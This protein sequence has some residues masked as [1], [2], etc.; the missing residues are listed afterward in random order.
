LGKDNTGRAIKR[1]FRP[2]FFQK[3]SRTSVVEHYGIRTLLNGT[4]LPGPDIGRR[5]A[6]ILRA[7]ADAGFEVGIHCWDHVRWQDHVVDADERWTLHEL[8]QAVQ[9]FEEIF[10]HAVK[11][12]GAAGWQMNA[13]AYSWQARMGLQYASDTRGQYPF[14]PVVNDTVLSCI[15]MPTTLPTLDELLGLN[16]TTPENVHERLLQ[17]TQDE[18]EYGHVFTLHAELEG[19]KLLPA[20]ERMLQGWIRQGYDL[21]SMQEL[22]QRLHPSSLPKHEVAMSELAGRSGLLAVQGAAVSI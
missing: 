2:G 20:M 17:A 16:D 21:I 6:D 13:V 3:V 9:R 10:G 8:N 1:I 15:Q 14:Q 22:Y 7:T 5:C 12:H 18:L 19:M 4:L 11:T